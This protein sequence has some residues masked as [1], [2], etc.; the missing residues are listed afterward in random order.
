VDKKVKHRFI[1]SNFW[2]FREKSPIYH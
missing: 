1:A 2:T